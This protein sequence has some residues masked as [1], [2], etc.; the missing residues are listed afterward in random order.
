MAK[1]KKRPAKDDERREPDREDRS[2]SDDY[3]HHQRAREL[4]GDP[5]QG[6]SLGGLSA[7]AQSTRYKK[8]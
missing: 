3:S 1:D 4:L 7:G 2:A 8:R 5:L 6:V